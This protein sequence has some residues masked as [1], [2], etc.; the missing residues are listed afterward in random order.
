MASPIVII[1]TH[2]YMILKTIRVIQPKPECPYRD[3]SVEKW[4]RAG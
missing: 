3:L 2:F 1:D 4:R